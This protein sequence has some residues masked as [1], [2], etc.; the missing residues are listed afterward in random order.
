MEIKC[1]GSRL[2]KYGIITFVAVACIYSRLC[3]IYW[4]NGRTY[5]I[6]DL[7]QGWS[8]IDDSYTYTNSYGCDSTIYLY[9]FFKTDEVVD[10]HRACNSFTWIDGVT[11]TES[12]NTATVTYTNQYG[13]DS[14]VHLNLTIGHN[15]NVEVTAEEWSYYQMSN[16]EYFTE[17]G[18][19][20]RTLQSSCG[21]DSTVLL[22][23]TIIGEN[24]LEGTFYDERDDITY[25]T[26][27][28][29]QQTWFAEDLRTNYYADGTPIGTPPSNTGVYVFYY[30]RYSNHG[31]Y[32][33]APNIA[34]NNE[35]GKVC[36]TGWHIPS[37]TEWEDLF[38][39]LRIR[40]EYVCGSD[41]SFL[42]AISNT[43][44][45]NSSDVE[46]SPGYNTTTN[47]SSNLGLN[48]DGTAYVGRYEKNRNRTEDV[49]NR[50]YYMT[51]NGFELSIV[52]SNIIPYWNE[53]YWWYGDL[54]RCV[55]N[56]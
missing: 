54:I 56:D 15:E 33:Y 36:P 28:Y 13:C 26:I 27:Q 38:T 2:C 6:E 49:G 7:G 31:G 44:G 20:L 8:N 4:I 37:R 19:Y 14:V 41:S 12:N 10:T 42:K 24:G 23:L 35:H 25:R 46:C 40:D 11:Y 5:T 16:G 18:D 22:H 51:S 39:T 52:K 30:Y 34:N 1:V 3:V 45:W 17:S 53:L 47:N 21:C 48:P 50:A 32:Y 43:S 55:R 29:G 9:L